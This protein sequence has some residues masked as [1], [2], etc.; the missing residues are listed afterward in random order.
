MPSEDPA[1]AESFHINLEEKIY[2]YRN[3]KYSAH[4]R[5]MNLCFDF[6]LPTVHLATIV[7]GHHPSFSN[8]ADAIRNNL[9]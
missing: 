7:A 5:L 3:I 6:L 1:V 9:N 8:L 4:I 2:W